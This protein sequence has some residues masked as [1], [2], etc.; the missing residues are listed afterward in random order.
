MRRHSPYN[1]AFNNPIRFID[2]DGMGPDDP[3]D[4]FL[5]ARLLYTAWKDTEHAIYNTAARA[6]GS[7]SR[8]RYKT[9]N[10][11]ETFETEVYSVQ[12]NT[13]SDVGKELL[14]T[15]LDL[16]AVSSGKLVDGNTLLSTT[17]GKGSASREAADILKENKAAGK[18]GEDFLN[19]LFG[20]TP[21][22]TF[23]TA[24]GK[25]VV[26]NFVDV[27][28]QESK[29]GRTA[30]SS[31]V[32]DQVSKDAAL[33]KDVTSGVKSVEWHFFPGKTGTGP[34]KQLEELLRKND[35]SIFIHK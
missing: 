32:K 27:T 16:A 20:G 3:N 31:R 24:E 8:M 13:A 15:G 14:S 34:T 35:F 29:V 2:P 7:D 23:N 5:F 4:P 9:S 19:N 25:R 12:L 11:S 22:K 17:G 28:A 10:G 21:Q 30:A 26:D 1:Y 18:A 33:I 6:I